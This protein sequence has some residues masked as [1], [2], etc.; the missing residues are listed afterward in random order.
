MHIRVF[1]YVTEQIEW[2]ILFCRKKAWKRM[3]RDINFLNVWMRIETE[4]IL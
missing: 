4:D 2:C 1:L 3:Q